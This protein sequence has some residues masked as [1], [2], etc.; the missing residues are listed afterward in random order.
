MKFRKIW[1]WIRLRKETNKQIATRCVIEKEERRTECNQKKESILKVN[2]NELLT[3]NTNELYLNEQWSRV[4]NNSEKQNLNKK[5]R[6]QSHLIS[7]KI[8]YKYWKCLYWWIEFWS[9]LKDDNGIIS[10]VRSSILY[11]YIEPTSGSRE[12]RRVLCMENESGQRENSRWT[13]LE[14][15]IEKCLNPLMTP[16]W[17]SCTPWIKWLY[18]LLR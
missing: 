18:F 9:D 15:K 11:A 5:A 14:R 16:P 10:V 7:Y 17:L 2:A 8:L 6:H 4:G 13:L 12:S 3:H 1:N